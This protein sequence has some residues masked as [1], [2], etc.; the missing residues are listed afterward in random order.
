MLGLLVQKTVDPDVDASGDAE[1]VKALYRS[2]S[3]R[4]SGS[5][6]DGEG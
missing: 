6:L 3:W 5:A 2:K 1:V 4:G